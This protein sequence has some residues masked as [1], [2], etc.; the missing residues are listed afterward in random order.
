MLYH[1][2]FNFF[3]LS[4][5]TKRDRD[6]LHDELL[7][8]TIHRYFSMNKQPK[9]KNHPRSQQNELEKSEDIKTEELLRPIFPS[10]PKTKPH[11]KK[12]TEKHTLI[13][14]LSSKKKEGKQQTQQRSRSRRHKKVPNHTT[15]FRYGFH[16]VG[17][18]KSNTK[19]VKRILDIAA[20]KSEYSG[21]IVSAN[22]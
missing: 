4:G 18:Q 8:H 13:Q 3:K 6:K 21:T 16:R 22:P 5:Y 1:H 20:S 14:I 15:L 11:R 7:K 19:V 17:G 10:A 12:R 9:E 2:C